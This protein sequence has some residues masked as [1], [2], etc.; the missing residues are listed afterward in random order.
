MCKNFIR[1]HAHVKGNREGVRK[2]QGSQWTVREGDKRFLDG[3]D[4][5]CPQF[6]DGGAKAWATPSD[7]VV[8]QRSL[9]APR[10]LSIPA[11]CSLCRHSPWEVWPQ[12]KQDSG[13][14]SSASAALGPLPPS[15]GRSARTVSG[16]PW[17]PAMIL[18]SY[19]YNTSVSACQSWI[20]HDD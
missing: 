8:W 2:G 19:L 6:Q 13:F 18:K 1:G 12:G 3:S 16:L 5:D 11:A 17:C 9:V 4:L 15:N 20:F 14:Q 7:K 10:K